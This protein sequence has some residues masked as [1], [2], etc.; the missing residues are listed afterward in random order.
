MPTYGKR[1]VL[2]LEQKL[3]KKSK[4]LES[5][6]AFSTEYIVTCSANG[7]QTVIQSL[8]KRYRKQLLRRIVLSEADGVDLNWISR[9][10]LR[11]SWNK[12]LGYN[13]KCVNQSID[14][15]DDCTTVI[16]MF[17]KFKLSW[18]EIEQWLADDDT[19]LFETLT[20]DEKYSMQWKKMKMKISMCLIS[21]MKNR[22]IQKP[23]VGS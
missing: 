22:A 16:E 15:D 3:S 4:S 8:K 13:K 18:N 7:S 20:D 2:N 5:C 12:L 19:P 17:E 14:C 21:Q 23:I 6:Y 10:T 9:S 1:K 11:A